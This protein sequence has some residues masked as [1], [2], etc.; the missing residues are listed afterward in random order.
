ML[1]VTRSGETMFEARFVQPAAFIACE[2]ARDDTEADEL[3]NAFARGNWRDV[4][5]LR[6]HD[7]P[8]ASSWFTGQGWWLS[9]QQ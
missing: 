4:R 8:D 5:S 7:P 9:T 3:S 2:G 1:L 6:R